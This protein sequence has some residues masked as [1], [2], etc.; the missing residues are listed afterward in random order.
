MPRTIQLEHPPAGFAATAMLPGATGLIEVF[1]FHTSDE[2]L[3]FTRR[4]EG[5][6]K[7][8]A[9]PPET[10]PSQVDHLLVV[11]APDAKATVY[12]NELTFTAKMQVTRGFQPG[13]PVM[14]DDIADI[15]EMDVGVEIPHDCGIIFLFSW[16]W[17]KGFFFDL[18]PVGPKPS[19]RDYNLASIFAACHSL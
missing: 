6:E 4:L 7:Y 9:G 17:R 16:R 15:T 8:I 13:D 12:V 19:P 14:S 11:I 2:G 18:R 10:S 5:C 3:D 1:G